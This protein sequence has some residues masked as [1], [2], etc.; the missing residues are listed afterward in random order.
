MKKRLVRGVFLAILYSSIIYFV[1]LPASRALA[2]ET[3]IPG[4]CSVSYSGEEHRIVLFELGTGSGR[5]I[6]IPGKLLDTEY[7][8][9][10]YRKGTTVYDN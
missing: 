8:N 3:G 1:F 7:F 4:L 10:L 5:T 6:V 2:L 9:P